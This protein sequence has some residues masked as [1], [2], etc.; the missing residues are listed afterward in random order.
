MSARRGGPWVAVVMALAWGSAACSGSSAAGAN[1]STVCAP[2]MNAGQDTGFDT[3]SNGVIRRRASL[4]CPPAAAATTQ[5]PA[6][7]GSCMSDADCMAQPLGYCADARHLAGYSGCFYGCRKDADCGAGSICQCG[8]V[9]GLCVP[10]TCATGADCG[11]GLD[12]MSTLHASSPTVC[13]DR[14][15]PTFACATS[16]DACHGGVDC[17]DSSRTPASCVLVGDHRVCGIGCI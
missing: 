5:G 15:H 14:S 3:C 10:A 9:V 1:A 17:G 4:D 8:V 12:C 13:P 6:A 7:G 16:A 2:V 11:A